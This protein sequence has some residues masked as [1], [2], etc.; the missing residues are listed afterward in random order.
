V[1][2]DL[3]DVLS[4]NIGDFYISCDVV[5][6]KDGFISRMCSVYGAAYEE[7]KQAF[8]DELYGLMNGTNVPLVIGGD[9]NLV[10]YQ[11]DKSNGCVDFKWCDKFIEWI[12]KYGLIEINL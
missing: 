4:W 11:K 8:I 5:N 3:F 9:F 10:S 7:K 2:N 6:K 1:N 12:D